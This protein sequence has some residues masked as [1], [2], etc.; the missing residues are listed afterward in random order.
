MR[1]LKFRPWGRKNGECYHC[2]RRFSW[3]S[4]L[5]LSEVNCVR[6]HE[7]SHLKEPLTLFFGERLAHEPNLKG[8]D[9]SG[10]SG[11]LPLLIDALRAIIVEG[12]GRFGFT[13]TGAYTYILE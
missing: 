4:R 12:C 8:F 2:T 5:V 9:I 1:E 13:P 7:L 3:I 11:I 6:E 10:V